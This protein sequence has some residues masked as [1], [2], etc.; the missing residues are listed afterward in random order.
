MG[1]TGTHFSALFILTAVSAWANGTWAQEK[2]DVERGRYLVEIGV[3]ASCHTKPNA[4]GHLNQSMHLAGGKRSGPYNTANLTPDVETGLGS[5]TEA[6]IVDALRN[7]K[8]PSGE[9]IRFPMG[10]FFYR[11]L[12]DKDAHAIA[13]YLK[14]IPPIKNHVER[15][16]STRP[17]QSYDLTTTIPEPAPAERGKYLAEAVAHCMQCHTPRVGL[18]PDMTRAG[19]GGTP[20]AVPGGG[21]MVAANLTPGNKHGIVQW[22]DEQVKTIITKGVRPDG[23]PLVPV[24]DF[25]MYAAM[26]DEDLTALIGYLRNLKPVTTD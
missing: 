5:W 8:R 21:T 17:D 11:H 23:T 18:T 3:C 10:I 9:P 15:L 16:P 12:S 19:A 24:M 26:T 25:E 20:Y 2:G 6:Q 14:S 13:A 1:V 7:G 4:D 22:T